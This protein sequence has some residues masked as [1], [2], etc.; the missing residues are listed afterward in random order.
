M[1]AGAPVWSS[2]DTPQ[3]EARVGVHPPEASAAP[4][5]TIILGHGAGGRLGSWP[6]DLQ[7]TLAA[8]G[9]GWTVVLVEQP[10]RVAGRKVATPPPTLDVA[11]RAVVPAVLAT[12]LPRPLVLGGRSAG[13]R[14]ACRTS[15]GDPVGGILRD[16]P[17]SV[18]RDDPG[19]MPRADAVLCLAFPLHPPGKPDRSRVAELAVPVGLGLPSLVVQGSADPFGS[20]GEV[21]EALAAELS[22]VGAATDPASAVEIVE[23]PG[24]HSPSRDQALV[25]RTV[26]GWLDRIG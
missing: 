15:P 4:H 3:G 1:S 13:A 8:T 21:R 6:K 11:W 22:A 7:S 24:N 20:P 5:G 2:V 9:H 25:T 12:G 26:I 18:P 19:S 17:G 14:V 10:W 16:D 23:V